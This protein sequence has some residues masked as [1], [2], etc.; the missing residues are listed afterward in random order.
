V[1]CARPGSP[2]PHGSGSTARG[3]QHQRATRRRIFVSELHLVTSGYLYDKSGCLA[4][5]SCPTNGG[6]IWIVTAAQD[7]NILVVLR[8]AAPCPRSSIISCSGQPS[9]LQQGI[10][11]GTTRSAPLHSRLTL[12]PL[13]WST[14]VQ[15][16]QIPRLACSG[17]PTGRHLRQHHDTAMSPRLDDGERRLPRLRRRPVEIGGMREQVLRSI[18]SKYCRWAAAGATNLDARCHRGLESRA[19]PRTRAGAQWLAWRRRAPITPGRCEDCCGMRGF[20]R[21][22]RIDRYRVTRRVAV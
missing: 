20:L 15:M 18:A 17:P 6:W 11:Q 3:C 21:H 22:E 4:N 16:G 1:S 10:E 19:S 12:G 8:R 14:G 9:I 2:F 13:G 5:Q 7:S